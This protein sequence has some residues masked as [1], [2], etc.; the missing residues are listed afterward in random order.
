TLALGTADQQLAKSNPRDY[1]FRAALKTLRHQL[2]PGDELLYAPN[3]L[4]DVI[5]YYTPGINARALGPR[6]PALP[7]H[8]RV[9]LL[10]SFLDQPGVPAAVGTA[11]YTIEHAG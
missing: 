7:H 2:R 8:G 11:K 10:A 3:Y 6:K 5:E 4:Q 9:F 1:D